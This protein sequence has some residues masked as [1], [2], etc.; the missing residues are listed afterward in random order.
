[1]WNEQNGACSDEFAV[2]IP[3]RCVPDAK[4]APGI[5]GMDL[6]EMITHCNQGSPCKESEGIRALSLAVPRCAR[7]PLSPVGQVPFG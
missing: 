7:M 1:M 2:I 5:V 4:G 3:N 6:S